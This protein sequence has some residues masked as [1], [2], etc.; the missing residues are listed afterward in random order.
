MLKKRKR[1][2]SP[3]PALA[4]DL[5][6]DVRRHR[7]DVVVEFRPDPDNPARGTVQGAKKRVWYHGAWI[8]GQLTD[9]QHEAADRYLIRLEQH[10]GAKEGSPTVAA[11]IRGNG[12]GG[13]TERQVMATADLRAA[14][15][16]LGPDVTLVRKVIGENLTP[17]PSAVPVMRAALQRLSDLWGL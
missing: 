10:Q 17:I 15:Q 7:G 14:D 9:E 2:T 16:V 3:G 8:D 6:P 5:G 1:H 4:A 11:G 12:Y 13:P